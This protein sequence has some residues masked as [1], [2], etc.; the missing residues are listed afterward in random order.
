MTGPWHLQ[1]LADAEPKPF[2]LDRSDAP[3]TREALVGRKTADLVVV[4]GGLTGLWAAVQA[5]EEDPS[6]DVALLEGQRIAFGASGRNGGFC[7]ASL[8]HGLQNGF[9]RWPA[10]ISILEQMGAENLAAIRSTIDRHGIEADVEAS[11][12]LSVATDPR[13]LPELE[14]LQ[15]LHASVGDNVTMLD[16]STIQAAI[17]SPTYHG[18]MRQQG[19]TIL[20]DPARLAWGLTD[21]AVRLGVRG[22][23]NAPVSAVCES[24]AHT[25][26]WSVTSA[27]SLRA[28][29]SSPRARSPHCSNRSAATSSRSTTTSS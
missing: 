25:C 3:T 2:W 9:E 16:Q 8:T 13:Q 12:L 11:G 27:P 17:A 20:V 14:K 19:E 28:E 24:T 5:K 22:C 1:A 6:R 15:K 10:E 23:M 21:A 4:G 18:A 7:S 26:A 29:S